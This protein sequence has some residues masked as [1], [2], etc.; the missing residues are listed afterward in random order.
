MTGKRGSDPGAPE[1][2]AIRLI[3]WFAVVT[4]VGQLLVWLFARYVAHRAVVLDPQIVWSAPLAN[5]VV[6]GVAA[7]LLV[8]LGRRVP[9]LGSRRVL[10]GVLVALSCYTI[11]LMV[12][13]I[14]ALALLALAAGIGLQ[15]GPRLAARPRLL[16]RLTRATL[17]PILALIL[18]GTALVNAGSLLRDRR[19]DGPA[20]GDR[21]NVLLIILDTVR[22]ASLGLYGHERPTS[23]FLD[24]FAS[25]AVVFDRAFSTAPWTLA[26]HGS[27]FTGY[28]PF[29]LTA[30]WDVPLDDRYPTLAEELAASGYTTGG[31]N[32]NHIFGPAE[33]GLA[34]GFH[35]YE[36]RPLSIGRVLTASSVL[37]R[38][39][40][41]YN[42]VFD[43]NLALHRRTAGEVT[44]RFWR[45]R[46]TT[47]S[48]PWFAFLNFFDAHEPYTPPAPYDRMFGTPRVRRVIFER[49]PTESDFRD[50]RDAYDGAIA[51]MDD[52]LRRL[53]TELERRGEL[54]RTLII[55][56]S[57][58]GE[59]LGEHGLLDHGNS[60]YAPLLHVPLVMSLPGGVAGGSR[61][62][63]AVTLRDLPN[64]VF[65]IV[66]IQPRTPFPGESLTR[67]WPEPDSAPDTLLAQVPFA[68]GQ[69]E[70]YPLARGD[71]RSVVLWPLQ[72]IVD[73]SGAE[74]V[75]HLER[76]PTGLYDIAD[77]LPARELDRLRA[78]LAAY[79]ER[80][81]LEPAQ[82][83]AVSVRHHTCSARA[84]LP[85]DPPAPV[86]AAAISTTVIP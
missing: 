59:H 7:A 83:P 71:I 30:G 51:Y 49:R 29:D 17:V 73:G 67:F 5:L 45:W 36:A 52:Q 70:W 82:S 15:L 66:G 77:R 81:R 21:P 26:A 76:D 74:E 14:H 79:P 22:A 58:H 61:V 12:P 13:R 23:P 85:C 86:R 38:L 35:H 31:F 27:F 60:L 75:F 72:L 50:V 48:G 6:F 55:I 20:A 54:D 37:E 62:S 25:R 32:A 24:E 63:R 69:P 11:L 34:R 84:S 4:G 42:R 33:Y 8:A 56:A 57:D 18:A 68:P 78:A 28:Y 39:Y 16:H 64:T 65:D 2:G 40:H 1:A 3:V 53:I 80:A 41:V 43:A 46:E 19:V 9:A 44:A 10:V 47:G